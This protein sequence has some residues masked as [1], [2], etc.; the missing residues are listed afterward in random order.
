MIEASLPMPISADAFNDLQIECMTTAA[1]Q[2]LDC[3]TV[4]CDS[5]INGT[6]ATTHLDTQLLINDENPTVRA[7]NANQ[8]MPPP[9]VPRVTPTTSRT[10]SM[11]TS[12]Y[13]SS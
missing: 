6:S 10:S 11:N 1:Y 12:S 7:S 4:I 8:L 2:R 3:A 13:A 9:T 5:V